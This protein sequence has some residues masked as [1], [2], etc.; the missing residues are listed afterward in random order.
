MTLIS[1]DLKT[2]LQYAVSST[3]S[4]RRL[5]EFIS[6]YNDSTLAKFLLTLF[7]TLEKILKIQG[8]ILRDT[9]GCGYYTICF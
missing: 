1:R 5:T 6:K 4:E 8:I 9:C 2:G 3:G 7:F